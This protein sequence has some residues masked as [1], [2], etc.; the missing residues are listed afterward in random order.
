MKG[1]STSAH[2]VRWEDVQHQATDVLS[3]YIQIDTTNPPGNEGEAARFLAEILSAEG[4][5]A[6][7]YESAPGRA[8]LVARLSAAESNSL[9]LLLLHHMD[10]VPA[11]PSAWSIPPF[12][13]VVRDGHVWGSGAIDDKGLGTIHLMA[14]V[15]LKRLGIPLRRD[16]IFMAVADEE[17]SGLYGTQW[18]VQRHWPDIECEYVWDEG[19]TGSRGVIGARPVFAISVS[20]KRSL[21]VR[22]TA[23]GRG[24]HGSM[25]SDTPVDRLIK[26][27]HALGDYRSEIRFNDVTQEFFRRIARTQPFPVS[28]LVRNAGSAIVKLVIV[29]RLAKIPSINAM[30]RDT[31]T[32]TVLAAGEK[33]NVAPEVAEAVLDARLLPDT[34]DEKFLDDLRRAINDEGVSVEATSFPASPPPSPIESAMFRA[35]ERAI[36]AHVP[37]AV[38]APLQTPVATD[39]RFFRAEGVNAYGLIPVVLT[40]EE[41]GTIHGVDERLSIESLTTGIK[42]ALDVIVELCG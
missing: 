34:R 32:P 1:S 5:D 19:G 26:A 23:R 7:L 28:W 40:P 6:A 39:S 38:V 33:F 12:D 11:E 31:L 18:M 37:G 9:P 17:E 41:L 25:A 2:E 35:Y 15:L 30:L 21:Q 14:F 20:E 42:I 10:V 36:A 8:N 24:G 16:V 27:L 3:R 29:G 13:G 4:I 22:L